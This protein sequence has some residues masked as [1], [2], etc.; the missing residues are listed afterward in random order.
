MSQSPTFYGLT[1]L[2]EMPATSAEEF[3]QAASENDRQDSGTGE[4]RHQSAPGLVDQAEDDQDRDQDDA[5][6]CHLPKQDRDRRLAFLFE[7]SLP[8]VAVENRDDKKA[9]E[10]NNGRSRFP[11]AGLE[12]VKRDGGIGG[13]RETEEL[14]EKTR[15]TPARRFSS[16]PK[17]S[18]AKTVPRK[19]KWRR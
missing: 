19:I 16:R 9:A 6:A 4:Q 1:D 13:Q 18:A 2:S 15:R 10:Q 11:K 12:A 17:K 3:L 5:E 7:V 14:I 8:E